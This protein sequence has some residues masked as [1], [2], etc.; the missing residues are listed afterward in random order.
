MQRELL[1]H[2]RGID[3]MYIE[4]IDKPERSGVGQEFEWL[5]NSN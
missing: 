3:F 2:G 5:F 1:I 4:R